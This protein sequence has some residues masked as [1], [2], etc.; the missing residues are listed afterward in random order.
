MTD[1]E[2]IDVILTTLHGKHS[3]HGTSLHKE[4]LKP[5]GLELDKV[6]EAR[7]ISIIK[8][9]IVEVVDLYDASDTG[10]RLTAYGIQII[11]KHG[12]YTSFLK[13]KEEF[14]AL[15]D[16]ID[17]LTKKNLILQNRNLKHT[18]L[19]IFIGSVLGVILTILSGLFFA[20]K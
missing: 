7:V 13:S 15:R 18:L 3:Q 4:I 20:P 6:Q 5:N 8:N 1:T 14:K 10:L 9:K 11:Q 2:L 17:L 19:H 16:E 12:S